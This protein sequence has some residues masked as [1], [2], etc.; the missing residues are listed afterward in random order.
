MEK[1]LE[2]LKLAIITLRA[3]KLRSLLTMLGIIIGVTSVILLIS[4]GSGLKSYI[5]SQLQGLGSNSLFVIPGN[6]EM[7]PGGGG[8]GGTP[9][10]GMA[11]SK[12][13]L[14]H[15][16]ELSQQGTTLQAVMGYSENNGTISYGGKSET[17]QVAGVSYE[18]P[19]V[20]NQYPIQGTFFNASQ[21]EAGKKVAVL[22]KTVADKLFGDEDPTGK[23][24]TLSDNKFTILGVLEKKG[25]F[26]S[27]DMDNQVFIPFTTALATFEMDK[28]QSI[29]IQ[30]KDS[31][32]IN[33]AKAEIEK[34]LLRTL[35]EDDFS[36]LDTASVLSVVSQVLGVLTIALAGIAA[37]SLIVGGIGIMNIMLVSVTERTREIGL[38]KAVGATPKII[39]TQFLIE[40]TVLS[41]GGG[42]IGIIL[43]GVGALVLKNF[44]PTSVSF[45]SILLAFSVS[46]IIGIVF[47][48]LPAGRAARLNPIQALRYE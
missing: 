35:K 6:L 42:I 16:R 36:V 29:W 23:K 37:I 33:E 48:V 3:N 7:K 46:V 32:Q 43:G 24:V 5:T 26:G 28:V 8:G 39:L 12:F 18:Y 47:G 22:G 13:T 9:G 27:V 17:L 11:A 1:L 30:A 44:I 45:G 34:I 15:L 41:V 38:R 14:S 4:I 20:R 2:T 21:Q 25:A 19:Q 31:N 10:A 40:S